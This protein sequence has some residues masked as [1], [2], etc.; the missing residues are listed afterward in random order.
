ML[1]N[2]GADPHAANAKDQTALKAA[3][4]SHRPE[5]AAIVDL[6]KASDETGDG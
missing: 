5:A 4:Q 2:R 3:M 6:L 1:L